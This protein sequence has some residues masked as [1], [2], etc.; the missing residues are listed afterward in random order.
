[1]HDPRDGF[2]LTAATAADAGSYRCDAS[3]K[4]N[5]ESAYFYVYVSK[6]QLQYVP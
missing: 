5:S 4:K 6:Y 2:T 1:M 3:L